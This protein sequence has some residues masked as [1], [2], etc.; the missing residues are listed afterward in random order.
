MNEILKI[1]CLDELSSGP[2]VSIFNVNQ[3]KI[4]NVYSHGVS[5]LIE[6]SNV[7]LLRWDINFLPFFVGLIY[8]EFYKQPFFL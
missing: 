6:N 7:F 2:E 4:E 3:V 8:Q 1:I 5:F